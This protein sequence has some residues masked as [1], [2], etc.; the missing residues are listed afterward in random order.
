MSLP[1][2]L[3]ISLPMSKS[4]HAAIGPTLMAFS[5]AAIVGCLA[6]LAPGLFGVPQV[7]AETQRV[8]DPVPSTN[9]VPSVVLKGG[10]CSLLEWPNYEQSCQFD[11]RPP[12]AETRTVRIIAV[13]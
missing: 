2:S 9:A 6:V 12:A 5:A 7:R 1:I 8:V 4:L 3:R 10:A 13:R 11:A